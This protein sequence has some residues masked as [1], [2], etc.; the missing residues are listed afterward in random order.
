VIYKHIG[1]KEK[2]GSVNSI[3]NTLDIIEKELFI[4]EYNAVWMPNFIFNKIPV[5]GQVYRI[6]LPLFIKS[7]QFTQD[8]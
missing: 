8:R 3:E 6:K 4:I 1:K 5:R 2:F 7:Y